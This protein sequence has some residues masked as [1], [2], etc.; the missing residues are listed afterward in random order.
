[1]ID[2]P[3]TEAEL[4]LQNQPQ[5]LN[6]PQP[7]VAQIYPGYNP[8][9]YPG[10]NYYQ[11]TVPQFYGQPQPVQFQAQPAQA[12]ETPNVEPQARKA[13]SIKKVSNKKKQKS[14]KID[15]NNI[16]DS[17]DVRKTNHVSH[18]RPTTSRSH[19]RKTAVHHKVV[20]RKNLN[21][22]RHHRER[23]LAQRY[24]FPAP[25]QQAYT[26]RQ[27]NY[28]SQ[29]P[30]YTRSRTYARKYPQTKR[31]QRLRNR[32]ILNELF[33]EEEDPFSD[34]A[35]MHQDDS[36]LHG[37]V[38]TDTIPVPPPPANAKLKQYYTKYYDSILFFLNATSSEIFKHT[39]PSGDLSEYKRTLVADAGVNPDMYVTSLN[40]DLSKEELIRILAGR[41]N[42]DPFDMIV[43]NLDKVFGRS[44]QADMMVT[45]TSDYGMLVQPSQ[46]SEDDKELRR[47]E[48]KPD[49]DEKFD[50]VDPHF[51]EAKPFEND[52]LIHSPYLRRKG[53][54]RRLSKIHEIRQKL[55][56]ISPYAEGRQWV[57]KIKKEVKN[58][59]KKRDGIHWNELF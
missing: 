31:G 42:N 54:Y 37:R 7:L 49:A 36:R 1:M 24:N 8:Q 20:H 22:R 40:F 16:L 25:A 53:L 39:V 11:Q 41:S 59:S 56:Q 45:M 9:A 14:F 19:V 28:R 13:R 12:I 3:K 2:D 4:T 51:F 21:T 30:A 18:K 46:E 32:R 52:A 15:L 58:L 38:L 50:E 29:A 55:D 5:L 6:A 57:S 27:H 34:L 43:F 26:Y 44:F 17:R 10:V 33:I 23:R 47:L 48:A 35:Q